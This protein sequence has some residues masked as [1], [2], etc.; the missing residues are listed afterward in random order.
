MTLAP[1]I[2]RY[3]RRRFADPARALELLRDAVL[4]DGKAASPRLLRCALLNSGGDIEKLRIEVA[5]MAIDYRDV[6]LGAEYE[7][8]RGELVRVRDLNEPLAE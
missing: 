7:K 3:V 6:I 1:D 5:H 4:H 2:E 8:Q